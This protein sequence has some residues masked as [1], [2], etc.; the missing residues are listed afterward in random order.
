MVGAVELRVNLCTRDERSEIFTHEKVV[1]APPDI[2][3]ARIRKVTPV[4]IVTVALREQSE[5]IYET[6]FQQLVDALALFLAETMPA[7]VGTRVGKIFRRMGNVEITAENNG[8][9]VW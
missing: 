1:D 8:F 9:S 5:G 7:L 3:V 4:R 2:P 6:G